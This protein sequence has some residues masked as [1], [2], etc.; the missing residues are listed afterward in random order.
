MAIY[1]MSNEKFKLIKEM[2]EHFEYSVNNGN[3]HL[4]DNT[5]IGTFDMDMTKDYIISLR[6]DKAH[7]GVAI[8]FLYFIQFKNDMLSLIRRCNFMPSSARRKKWKLA[9]V[10]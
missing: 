3:I 1:N 4:N 2:N 6:F 5:P 8:A 7:V 10:R 9:P